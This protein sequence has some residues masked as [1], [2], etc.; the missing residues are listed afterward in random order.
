[1]DFGAGVIYR[2]QCLTFIT[3]PY[4]AIAGFLEGYG[5]RDLTDILDTLFNTWSILGYGDFAKVRRHRKSLSVR[6]VELDGSAL[7]LIVVCVGQESSRGKWHP[8]GTVP[9]LQAGR[10]LPQQLTSPPGDRRV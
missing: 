5:T 3:F 2:G 7:I 6:G 1:M 4:L 10:L 8:W 9:G